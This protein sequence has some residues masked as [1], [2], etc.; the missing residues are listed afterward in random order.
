MYTDGS[1]FTQR[2]R[3]TSLQSA[4]QLAPLQHI[5]LYTEAETHWWGTITLHIPNMLLNQKEAV[6]G[7]PKSTVCNT[8]QWDPSC[9]FVHTIISSST[10]I[11]I[12]VF[13]LSHH[14]SLLPGTLSRVVNRE[15]SN[16]LCCT[17]RAHGEEVED[18]P[19]TVTYCLSVCDKK[20]W[21]KCTVKNF[22]TTCPPWIVLLPLI[23]LHFEQLQTGF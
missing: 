4:A 15:L 21:P 5:H 2:Q 6:W 17:I 1:A 14:P 9:F 12:V 8:D 16:L 11:G 7:M 3:S 22:W 19:I 23:Q 10:H 18:I 13:S 20:N